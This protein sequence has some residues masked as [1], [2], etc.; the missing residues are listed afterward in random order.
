MKQK[1]IYIYILLSL[2]IGYYFY[3]RV[4]SSRELVTLNDKIDNYEYLIQYKTNNKEYLKP[5]INEIINRVNIA[6]KNDFK[7][8]DTYI[9]NHNKSCTPYICDYPYLLKV[10]NSCKELFYYTT[11]YLDPTL[12]PYIE[13]IKESRINKTKMTY[14][15]IYDSCKSYIGS[16]YLM[17]NPKRIKKLKKDV[18]VNVDNFIASV[19]VQEIAK[20]LKSKNIND[21]YIQLNDEVCVNGLHSSNKR[22]YF[23][24]KKHWNI[25]YQIPYEVKKKNTFNF[26]NPYTCIK[27]ITIP[28]IMDDP[29]NF[30]EYVNQPGYSKIY[31]SSEQDYIYVDINNADNQNILKKIEN[32]EVSFKIKNK[33]LSIINNTQ[34]NL[35]SNCFYKDDLELIE[36]Y[37]QEEQVFIKRLKFRFFKEKVLDFYDYQ[38]N[39]IKTLDNNEKQFVKFL[40]KKSTKTKLIG[41]AHK[42]HT[43]KTFNKEINDILC[44]IIHERKYLNTS[45]YDFQNI[46]V[47]NLDPK[48]QKIIDLLEISIKQ[49][50][51]EEKIENNI[52]DVNNV[53][54][55]IVS[56]KKY[57][58]FYDYYKK[59]TVKKNKKTEMNLKIL[60]NFDNDKMILINP[61]NGELIQMKFIVAY[62]ISDDQ[63]YSRAYASAFSN[64]NFEN[65]NNVISKMNNHKCQY[66]VLYHDKDQNTFNYKASL[67]LNI[68]KKGNLYVISMK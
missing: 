9:L 29:V 63:I 22:M 2:G 19:A 13:K 40:I 68:N 49:N 20:Y 6:L 24:S 48:E 21:F 65:I 35:I 36:N 61:K 25:N 27:K 64:M 45:F 3:F 57:L 44:D 34:K 66:F 46:V 58:N 33:S 43:N 56:K 50:D 18:K 54:F 30:D 1:Q 10:L 55:D 59:K 38:N 5:N 23:S 39:F 4:R 12:E 52:Q 11:G 26:G 28:K 14:K 17:V 67:D 16:E 8:S 31:N 37:E 42:E 41:Y 60:S 15:E 7:G 51:D 53:L 47:K 62:I 32:I